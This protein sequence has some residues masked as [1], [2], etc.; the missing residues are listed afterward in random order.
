ME[1]EKADTLRAE[2]ILL[3]EHKRYLDEVVSDLI[4]EQQKCVVSSSK[5]DLLIEVIEGALAAAGEPT[6]LPREA[7]GEV[8]LELALD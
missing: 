4:R 2:L 3:D 6:S 7:V 1:A 5:T 8:Q